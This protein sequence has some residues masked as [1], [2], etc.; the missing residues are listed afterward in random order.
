MCFYGGMILGFI[1]F[2]EG[3]LLNPKKIHALVNMLVP[4]NPQ[5]M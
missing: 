4:T 2:E 1:V 5:Q 3:K